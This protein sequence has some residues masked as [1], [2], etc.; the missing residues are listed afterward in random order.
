MVNYNSLPTRRKTHGWSDD[1]HRGKSDQKTEK[2]I[3][4]DIAQW[5]D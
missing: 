3:L 4:L 5:A 1:H 2:K